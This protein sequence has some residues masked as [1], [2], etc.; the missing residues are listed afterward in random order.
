MTWI[1]PRIV[2]GNRG[3]IASRYGILKALV[4]RETPITAVFASRK[5]HVPAELRPRIL[6]YGPLYNLWP[7]WRGIRALMRSKAVIWTGGLDLKDDS[8]LVKLVHTWLVFLSFRLLGLKIL[9]ALQGAGPLTTG[10]GRWLT[11]RILALVHLA[12]VRDRG[13]YRLLGEFMAADRLRLAADGIF[14]D[15]FPTRDAPGSIPSTVIALTEAGP[16]PVVGL[17]VRLWF[18]FANS[19]IPYQFARDRYRKRAEAPMQA[20]L[21]VIAGTVD[22]LRTRHQARVVLLSMYEPG[23]DPWEDDVPLLKT[24]KSRF[25]HDPDVVL[26][27]ED[28]PIE[29]LCCLFGR[30]DLMIGM[31]LHS[32]LIALRAGVPALHIAYTLKGRDIY[33]DLGLDEWVIDID[34]ALRWPKAITMLV[35]KLLGDEE[36][37]ARVAAIVEPLVAANVAALMAAVN[38]VQRD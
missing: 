13:S 29:D 9:L 36:C 22:D 15:G 16:R 25:P 19:I 10:A 12:L 21:D 18:H 24:I 11:R 3:D 31:R 32:A 5:D 26:C 6:P 17:N 28:L 23:S 37:F 8:S 20:L 33:A 30:F 4:V 34:E 38:D 7:G 35:D 1:S 14:L 2:R 27:T